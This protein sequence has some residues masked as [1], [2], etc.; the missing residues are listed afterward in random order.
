MKLQ[1]AASATPPL[2]TR[3]L[4]LDP[5]RVTDADAMVDVLASPDL[6]LFTGDEPPTLD[7]LRS[8]YAAQTAGSGRTDE[9]WHNWIIRL[10]SNEP[11]G[12][13]QATVMPDDADVAWLIGP[14][15]QGAGLAREAAGAMCEWLRSTGIDLVHAHI[16]PDHVASQRVAASV[17]FTMSDVIDEDGEQIWTLTQPDRFSQID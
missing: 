12:F 1:P 6:Y 15:W 2:R 5:L 3:R 4:L 7:A 16:H 14:T 8:R 13:V 10:P 9:V 11:V 17:G